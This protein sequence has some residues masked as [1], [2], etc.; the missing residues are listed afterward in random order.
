MI[1]MAILDLI[2]ELISPLVNIVLP[3]IPADV[4][5]VI[6]DG[7]SYMGDGCRYLVWSL[8]TPSLF[9]SFVIFVFSTTFLLYGVDLVWKV[10]NLIKLRRMQ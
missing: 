7:I 5:R 10:I 6:R 9:R 3:L 1:F 8:W 2:F 4:L